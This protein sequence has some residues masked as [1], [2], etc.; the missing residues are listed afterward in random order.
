METVPRSARVARS[1]LR[2]FCALRATR[3]LALKLTR[4]AQRAPAKPQTT[5]SAEREARV[6]LYS[7]PTSACCSSLRSSGCV[8]QM[9]VP[10][11]SAAMRFPAST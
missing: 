8:R 3:W 1:A 11:V 10:I 9:Y 7:S 2:F 6:S 5:R 4:P